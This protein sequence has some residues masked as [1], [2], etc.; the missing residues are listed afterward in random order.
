MSSSSARI[1]PLEYPLLECVAPAVLTLPPVDEA[2]TCAVPEPQIIAVPESEVQQRV[3][4]ATNAAL[5]QA[6]ERLLEEI[7]RIRQ[8]SKQRMSEALRAFEQER[9]AYFKRV[10]HEV[11]KLSL[12]V[13]RKILE[14]EAGIDPSLLTTPVRR[15]L[16]G[17]QCGESVRIRVAPSEAER[18]REQAEKNTGAPRWDI[19]ADSEL[20]PGDC[21]VETS[22][23]SARFGFDA[24]MD[25]VEQSFLELLAQSPAA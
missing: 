12:A 1:T 2:A 8:D 20:S 15:T 13:A 14:R 17:M 10:E 18:W 11:V 22:V 3:Q 21:V 24:Q 9:Q 16:E 19:V 23:G 7:E 4:A 5:A 6:E 25:E